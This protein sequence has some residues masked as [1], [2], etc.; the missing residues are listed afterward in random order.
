LP[1]SCLLGSR[2]SFE[3]PGWH[4]RGEVGYCSHMMGAAGTSV[5]DF[6]TRWAASS[7][8]E[9]ANFQLFAAEL[10]DVLGVQRPDPAREDR[11]VNDYTFERSIEFKEADGST[12]PGRVQIFL[13][14]LRKPEIRERLRLIWIDPTKLDPT[15]QSAKVTR[16][17]AARLAEVSKGLEKRGHNPEDV[18][19]FLMRC[20]FT[21]FAEDV[22]LLPE[23]CFTRWLE[24]ARRS[25]W[26]H[27]AV[28][29]LNDPRQQQL[30][31]GSVSPSGL[32]KLGSGGQATAVG[33]FTPPA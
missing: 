25:C 2:S 31:F 9:R 8:A 23:G 7:G 17:I 19:H 30:C 26:H 5:E 33:A 3:R 32:R 13:E 20:L 10:C 18:A 12:S 27:E 28:S 4:R 6:I 11:N 1:L 14:D 22:R 16:D 24:G 15:R 29:P 21:M